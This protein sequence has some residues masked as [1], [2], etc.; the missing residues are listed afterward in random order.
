M[1][2]ELYLL[3]TGKGEALTHSELQ[4]AN[5]LAEEIVWA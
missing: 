4:G 5:Q 1:V 3:Q 2:I